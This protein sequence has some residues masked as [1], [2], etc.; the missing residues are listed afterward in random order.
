MLLFV[1][2]ASAA[3]GRDG[4]DA[5]RARIADLERLVATDHLTDAWS[6]AHFDRVIET[7][8]ARSLTVRQPL[9][10]VLLDIDHFKKVNDRLGQ[11]AGDSILRELVRL[12]RSR[13]RA[14]DLV[15]RWEGR[16]FVVL[17]SSAGYRGAERVAENLR[18]A[19]AGHSFEGVGPITISLGAA[20]HDRDEDAAGWFR[21]ADEA[22]YEAKRGGRNC[23]VVSRRG[24]SDAWAAAG[25]TSALQ[26]ICQEGYECGNAIVD[27]EHS[28]LFLRANRLLEA[29][30]LEPDERGEWRVALG[31]C[32]CKYSA[33]LPMRRP[34]LSASTTPNCRSTDA[35]TPGLCSG[36]CACSNTSKTTT[37]IRMPSSGS[38]LRT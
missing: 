21:R 9:S 8:L 27:G 38:W 30:S 17:I 3:E 34:S 11:V 2:D 13:V 7:E 12:L 33:T 24:N 14:S 36:R 37:A 25:R 4:L 15:F 22:L 6:R 19:V 26:L 18:Q 35:R 20:E 23:V 16:E 32:L 28:G 1:G 29:V 10:L 31:E 5:L